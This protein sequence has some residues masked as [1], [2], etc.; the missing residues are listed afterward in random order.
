MSGSGDVSGRICRIQIVALH[1]CPIRSKMRRSA[2]G[3]D[4]AWASLRE[5]VVSHVSRK[6]FIG[7][8]LKMLKGYKR[9]IVPAREG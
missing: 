3:N 8:S 1:A 9:F 6:R 2:G 7:S 5:R 4:T